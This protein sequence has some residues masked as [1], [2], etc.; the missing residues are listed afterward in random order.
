MN[1]VIPSTLHQCYKFYTNGV[2]MVIGD[3]K[4]LIE[5]ESQFTNAK[6]YIDSDV[7]FKVLLMKYHTMGD[8]KSKKDENV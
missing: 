4:P 8:S 2:K 1:G 3:L 7:S 6:V 5:A